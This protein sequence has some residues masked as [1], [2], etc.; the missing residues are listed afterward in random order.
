MGGTLKDFI[1]PLLARG[2]LPRD[3]HDAVKAAGF[4]SSRNVIDATISILRRDEVGAAD[5]RFGDLEPRVSAYIADV[6]AEYRI[7]AREAR[8]RMLTA[9]CDDD[10]AHAVL[11]DPP[12]K[13][14]PGRPAK[15]GGA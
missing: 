11:G 12:P 3:I 13:G 14:R 9:I 4:S 1:R 7:T 15:T 10:L 5:R 8:A 2:R 6:A